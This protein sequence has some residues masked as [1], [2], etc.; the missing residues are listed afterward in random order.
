VSFAFNGT[1]QYLTK[2]VSNAPADW[3]VT[4]F[5]RALS[6]SL[7]TTTVALSFVQLSSPLNGLLLGISGTAGLRFFF[8]RFGP[9]QVSSG[10]AVTGT[11]YGMGARGV[12]DA[13]FSVAY[14]GTIVSGS[15]SQAYATA[16]PPLVFAVGA[17]VVVGSQLYLN[18]NCAS[19]A[20]WTAELTDGEM[21]SLAAGFSPRRIRPQSLFIYA[22]LVREPVI[23]AYKGLGTPGS[24][25]L[26]GTPSAANHPRTYGM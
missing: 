4:L 8:N 9:S 15:G 2:T 10:D 17:R 11:W 13:T 21:A 19:A 20:M 7:A 14:D 12:A 26:V 1:S 25:T 24:L 3:P 16:Q 23:T 6:N 22:P 18:G 5:V